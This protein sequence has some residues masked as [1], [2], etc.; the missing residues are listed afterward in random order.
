MTP[1]PTH[2]AI[3]PA[4]VTSKQAAAYLAVSERTFW[5]YVALGQVPRVQLGP[6]TVRFKRA[7]LDGFIKKQTEK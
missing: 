5:K 6:N 3:A 7:D 1:P 2:P 4:L